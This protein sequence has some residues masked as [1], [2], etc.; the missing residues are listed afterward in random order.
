MQNRIPALAAVA[1][2]ALAACAPADST[3][4][5][6]GS[7]DQGSYALGFDVGETFRSSQTVIDNDAFY[8]GYLD[9]L[10]NE[11]K[12]DW[13]VRAA[14][15]QLLAERMET[16]RE[17]YNA[18]EAEAALAEGQAFLEQNGTRPEVVTLESG[19]QYEV[20]VEGDGPTPEM[21]DQVRL[22]YVG[23]L[24][25]GTQFDS[26]RDGEGEPVVFRVGGLIAGFNEA[27]Q[28][29]P[30]GGKFKVYIPS[31]LA[32]GPGRRSE[33]IGP[34]QVLVFEIEHFEIVE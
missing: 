28:L 10:A 25:D 16:A 2:L 4:G 17:S 19:V 13:E 29:I 3:G 18:A 27:M 6:I 21:G 32:Y 7:A 31:D 33:Q 11:S 9:G 23:T 20:L 14:Q 30:M 1:S 24:P 15:L 5:D 22:H 26:S 12:L 8:Q 34:N